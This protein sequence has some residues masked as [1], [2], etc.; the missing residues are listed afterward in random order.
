M[1][2]TAISY[3]TDPAPGTRH[4]DRARRILASIDPEFLSYLYV[5]AGRM[6]VKREV[7][8][9]TMPTLVL[10]AR[11]SQVYPSSGAQLLASAIP[12][13]RYVELAG[14]QHNP[15][16]GEAN[17]AVDAVCRFRG[18]LPVRPASARG[19]RVTVIMFT[20]L[21][22]STDIADRHG[23][24]V[25]AT[26]WRAHDEII[27]SVVPEHHGTVVKFTGDG[28]LVRFLSASAALNA[29][30]AIVAA[31]RE[32]NASDASPD[33][34][35]R[36][37]LNA[38]EPIEETSGDIHGTAVNLAARVCA[39]A[40]A[41]EVLVTAAVRHLATGKGFE[42]VDRGTSSLRGFAEDVQ[43]YELARSDADEAPEG[44]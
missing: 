34:L 21:V 10:H 1:A 13:A 9:L 28:A 22:A 2:S 15:W 35:I 33:L 32:H 4:E 37:G 14:A 41:N 27:E 40:P 44:A 26:M 8:E 19:G 38:G 39:E 23:D 29:A 3:V 6:D 43:L 5:L 11:D 30:A 31:A 12:G 17:V 36:V 42:F 24:A 7:A 16:E 20:D 18:L 25:A